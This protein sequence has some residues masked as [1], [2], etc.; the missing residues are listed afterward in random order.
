M[1][2]HTVTCVC[3]TCSGLQIDGFKLTFGG[4]TTSLLLADASVADV[5]SALEVLPFERYEIYEI[6]LYFASNFV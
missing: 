2:V 4:Q 5:V 3:T 1:L 6:L